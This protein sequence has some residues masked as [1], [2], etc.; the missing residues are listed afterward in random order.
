MAVLLNEIATQYESHKNM[1]Y[2]FIISSG[3]GSV[4]NNTETAGLQTVP[5]IKQGSFPISQGQGVT[6]VVYR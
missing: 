5:N 4:F 2:K 6:K 3:L 1:R